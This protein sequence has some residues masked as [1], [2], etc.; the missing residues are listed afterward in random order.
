MKNYDQLMAQISSWLKPDGLLFLQVL[1]HREACYHFKTSRNSDTEWMAKHFFTGGT[2]PST[3]LLLYFQKDL[4]IED[5]WNVNGDHYS[6]TLEAWMKKLDCNKDKVLSI[7]RK[8][9]GDD[10]EKQ[11]FNWRMFFIYCS[12]TFAFNG[13]NEWLVCHQL[14][15]KKPKSNL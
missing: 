9:H 15:K 10:A 1:C 7:F 4:L 12:E 6:R 2:M 5:H 8:L 11:V 3:D 13:G 14:F